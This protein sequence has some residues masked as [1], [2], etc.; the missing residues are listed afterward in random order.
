LFILKFASRA[1]G[2]GI[3]IF[4][5]NENNNMRML[6]DFKDFALRGNVLDLAIG[7]VIGAAFAAIVTSV[8]E[9]LLMPI[10]GILTGGIDLKS[11]SIK[12]GSAE[13][14]YGMF[15]QASVTFIIIAL[16]LFLIIKTANRAKLKTP[17]APKASSTDLLLMKINEELIEIRKQLSNK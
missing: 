14:K 3:I 7:I 5:G 16:F 2:N 15:L 10:V 6:K 1:R 13:L 4:Q 9:N 11:L 8:V 12:V 17:I